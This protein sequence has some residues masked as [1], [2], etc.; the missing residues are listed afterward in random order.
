MTTDQRQKYWLG[1]EKLG[2]IACFHKNSWGRLTYSFYK[3]KFCNLTGKHTIGD[4][5]FD[6]GELRA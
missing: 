4:L 6:I 1:M 2:L 5:E 3:R